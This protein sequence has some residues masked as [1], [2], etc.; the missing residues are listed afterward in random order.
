[1]RCECTGHGLVVSSVRRESSTA[2]KVLAAYCEG[3]GQFGVR[4]GSYQRSCLGIYVRRSAS[5]LGALRL[6]DILL[7]AVPR[8]WTLLIALFLAPSVCM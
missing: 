3:V 4:P 6:L 8:L 1:M 5:L 7:W 2:V